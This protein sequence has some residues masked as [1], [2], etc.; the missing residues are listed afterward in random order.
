MTDES[1]NGLHV[2]R[3]RW[4]AVALL[5][6]GVDLWSKAAAFEHVARHGRHAKVFSFG[7]VEVED[8]R[9]PGEVIRRPRFE[10]LIDETRNPAAMWSL[11]QGVPRWGWV[12]VRGGVC[13]LLLWIYLSSPLRRGWEHVG[14]LLIVGGALG[15]LYDNVFTLEGTV[16]DWIE[17][18]VHFRERVSWLDPW[19]IFNLADSF[20]VVGAP[21]LLL[22]FA[23]AEKRAKPPAKRSGAREG[24]GV[25]PDRDASGA[26]SE[27]E[28]LP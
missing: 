18:H 28:E 17:V 26:G 16:R 7:E 10:L 2:P 12:V 6:A 4:L 11:G 3:L 14:F 22:H 9:Q 21:L 24:T 20:I 5:L 19:P 27:G 13:L 8:P 1:N 25:T 23:V 15:N